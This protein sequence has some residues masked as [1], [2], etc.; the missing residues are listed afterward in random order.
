MANSNHR[1]IVLFG[2]TG[3]GKSTLA[4]I[5]SGTDEFKEGSNAVSETKKHQLGRNINVGEYLLD[6]VDTIGFGDTDLPLETVLDEIAST[7]FSIQ[8]G[9]NRLFFVTNGRFTKEELD[10]YKFLREVL[11]NKDVIAF[12]TIIRTGYPYF[13]M[14]DMCRADNEGLI[15]EMKKRDPELAKFLQECP[16]I[17]VEN[18]PLVRDPTS[19]KLARQKSAEKILDHFK[20]YSALYFPSELSNL[21]LKMGK[22]L[23]IQKQIEEQIHEI[24]KTLESAVEANEDI[25][26]QLKKK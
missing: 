7:C 23:R 20:E 3:N 10:A 14:P 18:P 21:N 5:L 26:V 9:F 2:R 8:D 6:I 1:T 15:T 16:I 11:F 24:K 17:H 19:A 25:K 4:N 13:D 12:T 22:Y